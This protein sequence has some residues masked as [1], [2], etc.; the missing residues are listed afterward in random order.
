MSE[1]REQIDQ[2]GLVLCYA[3]FAYDDGVISKDVMNCYRDTFADQVLGTECSRGGG[4]CPEC[5][6]L[7][8][9]VAKSCDL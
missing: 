4:V 8:K 6:H 1:I 3:L 7:W 9:I 5:G 2:A